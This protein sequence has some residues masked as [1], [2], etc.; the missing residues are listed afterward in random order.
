MRVSVDD[1]K[2]VLDHARQ[3]PQSLQ[4]KY[5]MFPFMHETHEYVDS[6]EQYRLFTR[7]RGGDDGGEC[8][9]R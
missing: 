3:W 7:N 8:L 4:S 6:I 5:M 1:E 2:Q 9:E